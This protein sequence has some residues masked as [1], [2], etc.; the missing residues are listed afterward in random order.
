MS[1]QPLVGNADY[2]QDLYLAHEA[3][4]VG[5]P[6]ADETAEVR[7][8]PAAGNLPRRLTPAASP[9]RPAPLVRGGPPVGGSRAGGGGRSAELADRS[10]RHA[11]C[12]EQI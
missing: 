12:R 2:P 4:L 6:E 3:E 10:A 5:E 11:N 7:W 8:V 9:Y 1:S